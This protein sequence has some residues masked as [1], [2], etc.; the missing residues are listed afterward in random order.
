MIFYIV[1]LSTLVIILCLAIYVIYSN[2]RKNRVRK[3]KEYNV[4]FDKDTIVDELITQLT[5]KNQAQ[6]DK[7]KKIKGK[8]EILATFIELHRSGSFCAHLSEQ[9]IIYFV[10]KKLN[11]ES[12]ENG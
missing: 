7:H 2:I 10:K 5:D 11:M 9:E 4:L 8:E 3:T 1:G 6:V 12:K